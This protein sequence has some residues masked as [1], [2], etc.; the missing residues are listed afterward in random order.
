VTQRV[1]DEHLLLHTNILLKNGAMEL[2]Y[3]QKRNKKGNAAGCITQE[4]KSRSMLF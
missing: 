1:F 4:K 3:L 2:S